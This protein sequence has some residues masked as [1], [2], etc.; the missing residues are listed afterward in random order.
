MLTEEAET[1]VDRRVGSREHAAVPRREQLAGVEGEARD[2]TVGAA[3][4][5]EEVTYGKVP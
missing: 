1:R 4:A 5:L 3:D 2:V